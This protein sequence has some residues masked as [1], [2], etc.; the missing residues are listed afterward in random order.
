MFGTALRNQ[1]YYQWI[2]R[3]HQSKKDRQYNGQKKRDKRTNNDLQNIHI[4]LKTEQYEPHRTLVLI[5]TVIKPLIHWVIRLTC[6]RVSFM[7][8]YNC[9]MAYLRKI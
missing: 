1:R 8:S 6:V 5:K 7:C 4:K 3:S 9:I 2:I